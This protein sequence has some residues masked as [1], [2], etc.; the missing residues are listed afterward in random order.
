VGQHEQD[1]GAGWPRLMAGGI[2]K[3]AR[4]EGRWKTEISAGFGARKPSVILV[5]VKYV[6]GINLAAHGDSCLG[7]RC[8]GAV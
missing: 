4:R 8:L 5:L 7:A 6:D 2:G 1:R 3:H